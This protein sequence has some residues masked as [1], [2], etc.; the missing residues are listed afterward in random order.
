MRKFS[1]IMKT[2]LPS[3][4]IAGGVVLLNP[5]LSQAGNNYQDFEKSFNKDIWR[6]SN[7]SSSWFACHSNCHSS[8]HGNC[9]RKSW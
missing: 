2:V 5:K 9:G 3:L 4:I 1:P 8:C 7:M 6:Q